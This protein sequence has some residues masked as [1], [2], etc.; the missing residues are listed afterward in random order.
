VA[1][2]PGTANSPEGRFHDHLRLPFVADPPIVA[3]G[4]QRLAAAWREYAA[5]RRDDRRAMDVLV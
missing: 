4:I 3:E 5:G 2:V 1:I